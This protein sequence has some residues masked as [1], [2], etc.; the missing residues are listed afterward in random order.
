MNTRVG[1]EGLDTPGFRVQMLSSN[2]DG[3]DSLHEDLKP[4]NLKPE[5]FFPI[6]YNPQP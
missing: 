5:T 3:I 2:G 6:A 1:F 4:P